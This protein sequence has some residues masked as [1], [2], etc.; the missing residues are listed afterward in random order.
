M[1]LAP[2][3]A[4][5]TFRSFLSSTRPTELRRRE[6]EIDRELKSEDLSVLEV[7]GN[8]IIIG[9][10][11]GGVEIYNS[12]DLQCT[13]T[14]PPYTSNETP[15]VKCL[16]C[17]CSELFVGYSDGNICFWNIQSGVLLQKFSV[18]NGIGPSYAKRMK[19]RKPKLIVCIQD[20]QSCGRVGVWQLVN[21]QL[22]LLTNWPLF[23]DVKQMD[24]DMNH[25]IVLPTQASSTEELSFYYFNGQSARTS[26]ITC[27]SNATKLYGNYLISGDYGATVRIWNIYSGKCVGQLQGQKGKIKTVDAHENFILSTDCHSE[28]IIWSLELA[29]ERKPAE[30]ARFSSATLQDWNAWIRLGRNV[31]T[32]LD[33][34]SSRIKVVD[35]S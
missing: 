9:L 33:N 21:S 6:R 31:V 1:H 4:S 12:L 7:C 13:L 8:K 27:R 30:V 5:K 35:F 32:W 22:T 19:W 16:Q 25:I 34:G 2:Q 15:A 3:K 11:T 17:T 28:T 29:L 18:R 20:S 26:S 10:V 14:L 24:F 23:D